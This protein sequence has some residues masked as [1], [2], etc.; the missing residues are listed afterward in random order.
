MISMV[1]SYSMKTLLVSVFSSSLLLIGSAHAGSFKVDKKLSKITVDAKATAHSFSGT[2][3]DYVVK[4]SGSSSSL[5]PSSFVLEWKFKDLD[6]DDE[7]RNAEMIKWLGEANPKGSF[8][9]I[10]TWTAKDGRQWAKGDL[11]IHGVTKAIAFPYSVKKDGDQV[12]VDGTAQMDY[13][14]F[15]L[16]IIRA[17]LVMKVDPKLIVNFH[18][19][20]KFQ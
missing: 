12:I 3:N 7:K 10:K 9:F 15:K 17:M 1:T 8:K 5:K 2:L 18:V 6:T 20:G 14:D 11:K 13:Q 16:P 19:V 4:G